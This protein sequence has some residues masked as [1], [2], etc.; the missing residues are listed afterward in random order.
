MSLRGVVVPG[1]SGSTRLTARLIGNRTGSR[2]SSRPVVRAIFRVLWFSAVIFMVCFGAPPLAFA[3]RVSRVIDGDTV[4]L[5]DGRKVRYAG[6][7]APEEGEPSYQEST[8]ANNVL[9]GN[10]EVDLEFGRSKTDKHGRLLAYVFVGRTF[11]QAELVKQGWALAMRAQPLPRYRALLLKHQE[12]ARDHGLGIWTKSEHRGQLAVIEAHPRESRRQSASDE[13]VVFKN[14]GRTLLDLTGW[15]VS[16]EA[17]R[18][19]LIPRF[20]L[21]SGKSLT[22]Y[23][24][25]GKNTDQSLYWGRRKTV[26]NKG[27]DTVIVKDATG[28]YVVGYTYGPKGK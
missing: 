18:S 10:K 11:I 13:Y 7:N 22:L 24:G 15:S 4:Q 21:G 9:V 2:G 27:G 17:N 16:D 1:Q 25:P 28:H 23:T 12:E 6:I 20:S 14:I 26:W 19:Y 8:Q 3:E 5:D